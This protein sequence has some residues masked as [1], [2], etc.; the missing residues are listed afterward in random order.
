[1]TKIRTKLF[2]STIIVAIG[3]LLIAGAINT[4]VEAK[5]QIGKLKTHG[6][7]LEISTF[8]GKEVTFV[9]A[10]LLEDGNVGFNYFAFDS[11]G[12][13]V[14]S[15]SCIADNSIFQGSGTSTLS[16][17]VDTTSFTL[18]DSLENP[19]ECRES[20]IITR[21]QVSASATGNGEDFFQS[22]GT[23]IKCKTF[24]G[25]DECNKTVGQSSSQ[26][27]NVNSII[28]LSVKPDLDDLST[29]ASGKIGKTNTILQTWTVP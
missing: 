2:I 12:M 15:A 23:T 10:F 20:P 6:D 3:I 19:G 21:G 26:S 5:T 27:A 24:S 8:S 16:I 17:N 13:L 4:Y 11:S 1:M 25:Y 29:I 7:T 28:V 14:T 18:V 9:K 22:S